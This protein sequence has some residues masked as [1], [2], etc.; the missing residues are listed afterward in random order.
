MEC[1]IL[2]LSRLA[3]N[4]M[5]LLQDV[6]KREKSRR[7]LILLYQPR[8]VSLIFLKI[9]YNIGATVALSSKS[10]LHGDDWV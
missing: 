5:F 3:F 4:L 9:S 8:T 10:E 2:I 7:D 1:F 6:E